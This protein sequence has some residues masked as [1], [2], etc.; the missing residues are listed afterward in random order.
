MAFDDIH[1]NS[2]I[3][4]FSDCFIRTNDYNNDKLVQLTK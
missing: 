4:L 3:S 2:I 1:K